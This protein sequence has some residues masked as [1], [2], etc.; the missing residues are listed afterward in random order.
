MICA[1]CGQTIKKAKVALAAVPTDT[2]AMTTAQLYAHYKKTA[3]AGDVAFM[4]GKTLTPSLRAKLEALAAATLPR[5]EFY[6][7]YESLQAEWRRDSNAA[8]KRHPIN[9][10]IR[11]AKEAA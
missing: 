3:P 10:C 8:H 5:A 11:L 4:L 1:H 2:A 7:V 6:R 9:R